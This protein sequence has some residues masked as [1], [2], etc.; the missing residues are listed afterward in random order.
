[1]PVREKPDDWLEPEVPRQP[2]VNVE[3]EVGVSQSVDRAGGAAPD[4]PLVM[5]VSPIEAARQRS[6]VGHHDRGRR[7]RKL[8][9][10]LV[11]GALVIAL[12]PGTLRLSE[13]VGIVAVDSVLGADLLLNWM[14][15]LKLVMAATTIS[16]VAWRLRRRASN[17]RRAGYFAGTWTMALAVG[18]IAIHE[19]YLAGV[20]LFD[21]AV[22]LIVACTI[23]DDVWRRER[24]A[25]VGP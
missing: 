19:N 11:V 2:R 10:A 25:G 21:A 15:V 7:R 3:R 1:M 23:G 20:V 8:R 22:V 18:F 12:L 6:G 17:A 4:G 24:P 13:A 16:A 9:S 5:R 14:T